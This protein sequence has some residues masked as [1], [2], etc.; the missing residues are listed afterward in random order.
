MC[1]IF[2]PTMR[3]P[4]CSS[5]LMMS[6]AAPFSTASGLMMDRVRCSVFILKSVLVYIDA[7]G[8]LLRAFRPQFS[9]SL[10]LCGELR[11]R[12]LRRILH[13]HLADLRW[14]VGHVNARSL[15]GLDFLCRGSLPAGDDR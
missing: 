6:P 7:L 5:V 15:H 3:K 10:R 1:S 11:L 9:V 2:I 14:R 12:Q 13:Q 4:F 8:D